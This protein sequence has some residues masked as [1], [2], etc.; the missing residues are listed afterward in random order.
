ML[1]VLFYLYHVAWHA[2]LVT[3]IVRSDWID[4]LLLVDEPML[5]VFFYL[6]HAAWY[7]VLITLIVRSDW[8]GLFILCVILSF[9]IIKY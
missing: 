5:G 4:L 9:I 8:I 3:L 2:V 7:A 1:G 6:Y